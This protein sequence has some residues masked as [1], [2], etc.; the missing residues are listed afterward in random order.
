MTAS[1]CKPSRKNNSVKKAVKGVCIALLIL[2]IAIVGTLVLYDRF[3]A[4]DLTEE[5]LNAYQ[6]DLLQQLQDRKGEYDEQSIVLSDTS[7]AAA[8]DLAKRLNAELRIT[9]DG[10]FAALRL[11]QGVTIL[12]VCL[13]DD[14]LRD[15]PRMSVDYQARISE[16]LVEESAQ[17]GTP[18]AARPQYTVTDGSYELQTYLDY[19][20]LKNTWAT[21]KGAGVTV[22]VIDTGIDT[23]HPEFAGRIS[24][25]SYN[26][27]EDKIVKDYTLEN[28]SYDWSLIED[29]HGHGTAVAGVI[30]ASMGSGEIVG[31][32]PEVTLLVIKVECDEHGTF[33]N[34]SDLVFGL[35]YAIE[36]DAQVVNM[37]F[38]MEASDERQNIFRD[39]T[40]LAYDSDIV[41]IAAAGN[42]ASTALTYP[43]ADSRVFGVGALEADGWELAAYSNYGENV[44]LVAPGSTYTAR[45]GGYGSTQGTS[46]AA[47]TVTG[48]VALLR[49]LNAYRY[50]ESKDFEE[51]L[52]ASCLDLGDLG[53][54]PYFGYGALDVSALILEERGKVTFHM[55]TD[56]LDNTEQIFIR[57]H[58]LQNIPEPERLYA[59]FDGWYYDPQ[60]TE[61]YDWYSDEFS[62]DLTLYA[63]WVNEEDGIPYVY[64]ELDDGTIE[65]RSYTGHRRYITIPDTI[66]GKPV[67]SIGIEAFAKESDLREV[68]LPSSLVRIRDGAFSGCSNLIG[69]T[70]PDSV[71]VIGDMA[72][73]DNLRLS[74]VSFGAESQLQS[75]GEFAFS[76]CVKLR[77]FTLPRTVTELS[78][79]AFCRDTAII[80]FAVQSGNTAYTAVNGILCNADASVLI[81]YPYGKTGDAVIPETVTAVGSYGFRYAK[82]QSVD[83]ANVQSIAESAFFQSRLQGALV[84][85]DG[86]TSI[87]KAAFAHN[88]Y[89]TSLT[90][91]NGLTEIPQEAFL[92]CSALKR[93]VFSNAVQTVGAKAFKQCISLPSVTL[94]DSI[95]TIE[96]EAF[97]ECF[98]LRE[99]NFA[100]NGDLTSIGNWAFMGTSLSSLTFP[101]SLVSIG[102]SA[103][104][105]LPLTSVV[106]ASNGSLTEIGAGAF[107]SCSGITSLILPESLNSMGGEAFAGTS[108]SQI[109]IPKS[110]Q[111]FGGGA[112]ASCPNLTAIDVSEENPYYNAI[113]GAVYSEDGNT[114]V[115][116]PTGNTAT[117]YTVLS[118]TQ[119][120]GGGSFAGTFYLQNAISPDG[121]R[122]IGA[123]AF[124]RSSVVT[125]TLGNGLTEIGESAFSYA[126]RLTSVN[127]PEG[128]EKVGK[129]AFYGTASLLELVIPDSLT[130][131]TAYSFYGCGARQ[132]TL[133]E[134]LTAIEFC[135]MAENTNLYS[136]QI[137]DRVTQ[138]GRY[139]FAYNLNMAEVTF[140][141]TTQL[142]RISINSF[143]LCGLQSFTVPANVSTIA[144]GAFA[145]CDRLT[146][147]TFAQN[148][149]LTSISAYMFDGC[150]A[151]TEIVFQ[152]GSALTSVQAHGLEGMARLCRVDFGDAKLTEI[153]NFAFRFCESLTEI[154]IPE[155][156]VNVGR[157]AFYGCKSLQEVVLPST[158]EHIGRF[159]FLGTNDVSL[160]FAAE[161]LPLYLD[162]DWDHDV[163]G[164][165][166]GVTD[167][168][169]AAS[170]K[171][172][173]LSS[174][175]VAL[176]E[177][178]GNDTLI[179]LS[180]LDLGGK[181]VTLGGGLFAYGAIESVVLPDTLI[182]IQN[183]AFYHSA[184]QSV[185]IPKSLQFIGRAAFADTPLETL[186]FEEGSALTVIEQS[187]FENTKSLGA[188]SLPASLNT[189]G[190]AVFQSS[191]ITSLHFA[192]G[193]GITEIPESA[194]A[195]SNI[196]SL[197]LP[198]GITLI[199]HN[200]F[201]N[202]AALESVTFGTAEFSVMSNAFYQSGL[203]ALRI[204]AN[205][206]YIGEYAFVALSD[207][208]AFEVDANNPYYTATDGLLIGS[209]G[210]KLIA[211][212]AGRTG[213]LTV[214]AGIEVLG[215]GAFEETAL[216]EIKFLENA[217]ILS[218]GYRAFYAAKNVTSIHIPSSVV[219]I[220][221]YAFANCTALEQVTFAEGSGLN[222]VYEGAFYGCAAL[223][224]IR[225]PN[226]IVEISDFAF[227]GC[228]RLTALPTGKD[229]AIKGIYG[230]AMAYTGL[231]GE[232]T[233]P[234]TLT[235]IGE[236]AFLGTRLTAV[237]V[238]DVNAW[239][240]MIGI[241]AFEDCNNIE[242][243]TLPFIGGGFEDA[244]HSWFGY[245]FGAGSYEASGV[246]VPEK[247]KRITVTEGITALGVGAFANLPTVESI[248]LPHSVVTV[249]VRAFENTPAAY[250]LTNEITG[251]S[252]DA[253]GYPVYIMERNMFGTGF[254]GHLAIS[255]DVTKIADYAFMDCRGITGVTIGDGVE[256]LGFA[257]FEYCTALQTVSFGESLHEIPH[258]AFWGCTGLTELTLPD[259]ITSIDPWAF[260]DCSNLESVHLGKGILTFDFPSEKIT[261]I[262]ISE[263]N[264]YLCVID[265]IVYDKP[266]SKI[267]Y[268]PKTLSGK[269]V[270]ADGVTELAFQQFRETAITEVVLPDSLI[271]VGEQAFFDCKSLNRVTLG[272][273]VTQIQADAFTNTPFLYEICNNSS[274]SLT[275]GSYDSHGGIAFDAK[276]IINADGS[277]SYRDPASG[278]EFLDTADGFRFAKE[279]GSYALIA[280]LGDETAISLPETANGST[281][282][283]TKFSS[284]VEELFIPSKVT[285]IEAGAFNE[286]LNLKTFSVS[287][288]NPS[289]TAMDGILYNAD[290]TQMIAVPMALTGS[291]T[292]PASL[293]QLP[294]DAFSN[295]RHLTHVTLEEGII[296]VNAGAFQGCTA[297]QR[298]D[299]PDTLTAIGGSA[300][301][302]C[303]SL[304]KI[305]IPDRVQT[306]SGYTFYNCTSLSEVIL[307]ERLQA[308]YNTAF[309]GCSALLQV[310]V[311]AGIKT[312]SGEAFDKVTTLVFPETIPMLDGIAYGEGFTHILYVPKSISGSV[313]VPE[314]ITAI[315]ENAFGNCAELISV[316]L[317]STLKSIG[318][319]AFDG[320]AKL[321]ELDIPDGVTSLG[322]GVFRNCYS[323]TRVALPSGITAI[324]DESFSGCAALT[325]IVIP[326][327]VTAVYFWAFYGCQSLNR[328]VLSPKLT[329]IGSQAFGGCSV[330]E[331]IHLPATLTSLSSDSFIN[332]DKLSLSIDAENHNFKSIDGVLYNKDCTE[333]VYVSKNISGSVVIAEG[334]TNIGTAFYGCAMLTEI[335]LPNS[336]TLTYGSNHLFS[337]CTGLER[338]LVSDTH[339]NHTSISGILYNKNCTQIIEVPR[340]LSGTVTLP[341]GLTFLGNQFMDCDKI[342]AVVLPSTLQTIDVHAFVYCEQLKTVYNNSALSL[343]FG[344][345]DNGWVAYRAKVIV[346]RNGSKT[347][348]DGITEYEVFETADGFRFVKENGEYLLIAYIGAEETVTLP[349]SVNGKPYKLHR[350]Q[351]AAHV[352][353]PE[354]MTE[355]SD[356]AFCNDSHRWS[357]KLVRVTLPST[358]K[359][360]GA[361][362][363]MQCSQ[364][365]EIVLPEGL[366][367]IGESA[368]LDCCA[369]R[370]IAFPSTLTK[371]GNSAFLGCESLTRVEIPITVTDLGTSLFIYCTGIQAV[372][373]P[374]GMTNIP[375]GIFSGCTSLAE[376]TIPQSV[377]R[378]GNGAF[379]KCEALTSLIIPDNVTEIGNRAFSGCLNLQSVTF[380]QRLQI[381][382]S[383]AFSGCAKLTSIELPASL[384]YIGGGEQG[385]IDEKSSTY[386]D[387]A[388]GNCT[389][390]R[391]ISVGENL[392]YIGRY[393]FYNTA[394]YNDPN[395]W[396][397]GALY[398]SK[399]LIRVSEEIRYFDYREDTLCIAFGA[400]HGCY[401]LK[402]VYVKGDA[403]ELLSD[404]TNVETLVIY[405]LPTHIFYYFGWELS[406]IPQTLKNIV[407][408]SGV[409]M[410]HSAFY[411]GSEPMTGY[412]IYVE[413]TQKD[414]MWDE[415]YPDWQ[416][417]NRVFYGGKWITADF[418]EDEAVRIKNI[419]LTSQIVRVPFSDD[420]TSGVYRYVFLG[421]D[422]DGDGAPDV[423]PA[424]S[425]V[426]ISAHAVY[427][428][429][430]R[431]VRE[432]HYGQATCS[433][434][435]VC[436]YCN[437]AFGEIA[438]HSYT[439]EKTTDGYL[440]AAASCEH[441]AIYYKSCIWC[442]EAGDETFTYGST[443]PHSFGEWVE[444]QAPGCTTKGSAARSCIHCQHTQTK[445]VSPKGHIYDRQTVSEQYLI[446]EATCLAPAHY[447]FSC[448]CGKADE[449]SF[450]F[451]YGEPLEH[452]VTDW[453]V[454]EPPSC[455]GFGVKEGSCSLCQT[456]Q[457]ETVPPLGHEYDETVTPPTCIGEG[458]TT[459][460]CKRC[461]YE[462]TDTFVPSLGHEYDETVTPPTCVGEG[463]TTYKCKRCTYEYTDT[464]VPSLGHEYDE[465]VTPPTCTA[466]GYTTHKCQ[467]C[468]LEY[469]DTYVPS[470]GHDYSAT[471]TPP[472]CTAEG[473]TTHKCQR[474]TLKYT[475]TYV[476]SLGHDYSATLTPPTCTADGYTTHECSRCAHSYTTPAESARGHDYRET[477]IPPTCTAGGYTT[478]KCS[479]C[480]DEYTDTLVPPLGHDYRATVTPPTCTA[481][482]YTTHKCNRCTDEYTDTLVPSLGHD[483][484]DTVTPPTC[485]AEGYTTHKCQ[486]CQHEY[487]DSY[488]PV[489]DHI[490]G[491][492]AETT[493][494][495][496]TKVGEERRVC[497]SCRYYETRELAV[498]GHDYQDTVIPPTCESEGYTQHRCSRCPNSYNDTYVAA[499]GH[500][501]GDW[502][503]I[504]PP[505]C[506]E[507][508][509][510]R[511]ICEYC[512]HNE[513][514]KLAEL[515]HDYRDTVTPP[516]CT[517]EGY[518]THVCR[519]CEHSYE[520]AYIAATGHSFANGEGL[521]CDACGYEKETE[522]EQAT[523]SPNQPPNSGTDDTENEKSNGVVIAVAIGGAVA[524]SGG[525]AAAAWFVLKKRKIF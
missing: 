334:V 243:I 214:P 347:Y 60:C 13:N 77:T 240:L 459:Y 138:I 220:D 487:T 74:S 151:L 420:Y 212:P 262:T 160:Y 495:T 450:F 42:N 485:T 84:L 343:T 445:T 125:V 22:A 509:E 176:L 265:G 54:D 361:Y 20:N 162:E 255:D 398:L 7:R 433:Q 132:Y 91:G 87:G 303:T 483:Y 435:A 233:L 153:D 357:S 376:I 5:E 464:F 249:S 223:S 497:T 421:Y 188:V 231:S 268:V 392:T 518:T 185:T 408:K 327:N 115:A 341:E 46:L 69:I 321:T 239:D 339:P 400:Y 306:I 41:C 276:R 106:F 83:F 291:V 350:F 330:L 525:G 58:T 332:C 136:L 123:S 66:D 473:Y 504:T 172:A 12:D 119:T 105:M 297:L 182:T 63:N 128:L 31:I 26:A 183:E 422:T 100:E 201:R 418:Y 270:I 369:L 372:V 482:G 163:K 293:V 47:P 135:A 200:A 94:T 484:K 192:D 118:G 524:V 97:W 150:S 252:T 283:V 371:I 146:H 454:T 423:I 501:F 279:Y 250:T 215:F 3:L 471:L 108:I 444:T 237:T 414:T 506:T 475:D 55:M 259:S 388:F 269:L 443:L 121:V 374:E 375:D 199:N 505:T 131:L 308:I 385:E 167:V 434:R 85:S 210:R 8:K 461:T 140:R 149:K 451:G 263:E 519:R 498:L 356:Y 438:K 39:A 373:L 359:H 292:V 477:V 366:E 45:I 229:S 29:E 368:F 338:I 299:L 399:Y 180:A 411:I 298:V 296:D 195:Y 165:Y 236:Y 410:N 96:S 446:S 286:S 155:G 278:F 59:V 486:R 275:L 235:D 241:G 474:C 488:V 449:S 405:E 323:L 436:E 320:C 230:Y 396:D 431:C 133:P 98:S 516:T 304:T 476:P 175:G 181:I 337:N 174:G 159:A 382:D 221:Y 363:F 86:I 40:L 18:L 370:S 109:L 402:T 112:F 245:I 457:S 395:N 355:L 290:A 10:S 389:A 177:Y 470:L 148:S 409:T 469:T 173:L 439:G 309:W 508:G 93:I 191:G 515:G 391:S 458:Y 37:S 65:I 282:T 352:I 272:K 336:M 28:D 217:N 130:V 427:R 251:E 466:E 310:N 70:I 127:L 161:A 479:R 219:A 193:I 280:Y 344:S 204:P 522:S 289:F 284:L 11:P 73:Y 256:E 198:Q 390:L 120:I 406:D 442:G 312:I 273:G 384:N 354:G 453:T 189:L 496:C 311:P 61:K 490:L 346:D 314:G 437:E 224:D 307:P 88:Y 313:T 287:D 19:I 264:P 6:Q 75:I 218:F 478:H 417:G 329:S 57:D 521:I 333:I 353:L 455:I 129:Q 340:N 178:T 90:F 383:G 419:V 277:I 50:T 318:N 260:Y 520:D 266:V 319:F 364:L 271:T 441:P 342:S 158:L 164:Y 295:R 430:Y 206:T 257:A 52:Y 360:I 156:V 503:E 104:Q 426:N 49:S 325:E 137:P 465:I 358:L 274:L 517:A 238:P 27:T 143:A 404:V 17:D 254:Y 513:T 331:T 197:T 507:I 253:F 248:T 34:S 81:C 139:A 502:T 425:S 126:A 288:E 141:E 76:G 247:L 103:F 463:Y 213:S 89:L 117:D 401:K 429:E 33:Q 64:V 351:G 157:F 107:A 225:L 335:T 124:A 452:K 234:D 122:L 348:R 317:P 316:K 168:L 480:T 36:R 258:S 35:Y 187:A 315:P 144:Q 367:S 322:A 267:V 16:I 222:G 300:F 403:H 456:P 154:E 491:D 79:S 56:E 460:K 394:F 379:E 179:D 190:R 468:T 326:E 512:N 523:A 67:T 14:Y 171:Y 393:A 294:L 53:P 281:Y 23:D 110:L 377:Q 196:S 428:K 32:A 397:S 25:Y 242:E 205:M 99:L 305:T 362:A 365:E 228:A 493:P 51:L 462:Y 4:P 500:N 147:I 82:C 447:R 71:T 378:I 9:S 301:G 72:F 387:G 184:L 194:F 510:E 101:R 170:W 424:T 116:Y 246:Y 514:R 2:C 499:T 43:A 416:R 432:G 145:G 24:E 203:K 102:G 511:R 92:E 21:T 216:S 232:F 134:T 142:D 111:Y 209:D 324:W 208:T 78:H 166:L 62:A 211:V 44:D 226:E 186:T 285:H 68:H 261:D 30:G 113:D 328:V 492:W 114:F 345:T 95:Q 1:M 489:S 48:A 302:G 80:S 227:Y 381:I 467:R 349:Q 38:G 440:K 380:S 244:K 413:D 169:E 412:T 448:V 207:L 152:S 415:N 472:T 481:E 386:G 202:T 407:L 15:L 494:P